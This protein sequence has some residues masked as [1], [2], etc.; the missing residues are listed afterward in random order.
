MHHKMTLIYAELWGEQDLAFGLRTNKV[1]ND[2]L[3]NK[4]EHIEPSFLTFLKITAWK[5]KH[6]Q[7]C[8]ILGLRKVTLNTKAFGAA[9]TNFIRSRDIWVGTIVGG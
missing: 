7:K 5:Q 2:H 3:K 1:Q 4:N 6:E 9:S 8:D